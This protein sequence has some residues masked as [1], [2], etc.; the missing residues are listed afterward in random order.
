MDLSL[1]YSSCVVGIILICI[2]FYYYNDDLLPFYI[3]TYIGI[4][5]SILN[6]GTS[7]TYA[8]YADR[9][10]MGIVMIIYIYY[11]IQIKDDI[12]KRMTIVVVC[13]MAILY[14]FSKYIKHFVKNPTLSRHIHMII[15]FLSIVPFYI[16][17]MENIE[18]D[19][20]LFV[21]DDYTPIL[22]VMVI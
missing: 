21:H 22:P 12:I 17:I 8:K 18:P 10:I 2:S 5:T 1:F 19:N 16:I 4:L 15:H 20:T 9:I 7:N 3:I 6:H 14:F 13:L 11:S